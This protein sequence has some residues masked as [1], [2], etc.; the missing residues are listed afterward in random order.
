[1]MSWKKATEKT[2]PE[3]KYVAKGLNESEVYEFR[4]AAVNKVGAGPYSDNSTLPFS[5]CSTQ[6]AITYYFKI[7]LNSIT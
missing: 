1:M 6:S 4:V 7:L 2:I 5:T 3:T